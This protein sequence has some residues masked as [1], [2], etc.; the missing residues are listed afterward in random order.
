MKIAILSDIHGNADALV[1]VL[2]EAQEKKVDLL[3]VLGDFVGY[4]YHPDKVLDLLS[5]WNVTYIKGNHED[6][7]ASMYKGWTDSASIRKKYGSGHDVALEKLSAG[8]LASLVN[9]PE[10][11]VVEIDDV[12]F[13]LNHG[14][15]FDQSVYL[16]PDTEKTILDRCDNRC[17]FVFVG[18]SHHPFSYRM[19]NGTLVNVGS[20][21]QSR[22]RG[23][24]ASWCLFNT[25]NRVFQMHSTPYD[26]SATIREARQRDPSVHY[27][28][29]V[30]QRGNAISEI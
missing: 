21:G 1:K 15:S 10:S 12:V 13:S 17:D 29:D 4:Y 3:F 30:L 5:H 20:V 23:G 14:A 18:H 19:P 24:E 8:Q 11:R 7:L 16:Y 22:V 2:D 26:V 6:I 9:A 25:E 28:W 27:L